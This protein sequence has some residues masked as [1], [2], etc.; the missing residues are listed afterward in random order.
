MKFEL[1]LSFLLLSLLVNCSTNSDDDS[2]RWIYRCCEKVDDK[3]VNMCEPEIICETTTTEA[4][5]PEREEE[6]WSGFAVFDAN[7]NGNYRKVGGSCR[8]VFRK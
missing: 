8:K 2:C 3:C 7:C 4:P 5:E 1:F 6:A